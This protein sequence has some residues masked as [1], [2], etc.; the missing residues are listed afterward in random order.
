MG[1][2][3]DDSVFGPLV[4]SFDRA[5]GTAAGASTLVADDRPKGLAQI[6]VA[7]LVDLFDPGAVASKEDFV[8]SLTG[9]GAGVT[10]D[11]GAAGRSSS[12]NVSFAC[13]PPAGFMFPLLHKSSG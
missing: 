6:G 4:G 9:R 7:S 5:N 8:F 2:D 13:L 1:V 12:S 10:G 11:S 3:H